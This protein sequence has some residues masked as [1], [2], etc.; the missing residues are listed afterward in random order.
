MNAGRI[1]RR[2]GHDVEV[3]RKRLAPIDP[4]RV[5]IYPASSVVRLLLRDG[6]R[7]VTLW[8][9]VLIDPELL[10]AGSDDQ[11]AEVVIHEMVHLKQYAELGLWGFARSYLGEYLRARANGESPDHAY[12]NLT[13][14][15]EARLFTEESA[16]HI[17]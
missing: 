9:W 13:A 8:K 17:V 4:D 14:E 7:A 1:V 15:R 16:T 6:I 3:L 11:V 12:L 5:N 2:A 10:K